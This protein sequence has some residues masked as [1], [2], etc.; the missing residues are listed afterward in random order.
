[1]AVGS[2]R[3]ESTLGR[4]WVSFKGYPDKYLGPPFCSQLSRWGHIWG[5]TSEPTLFNTG[6]DPYMP[7]GHCVPRVGARILFIT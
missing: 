3:A 1:M 2:K 4:C 5:V 6:E 7:C